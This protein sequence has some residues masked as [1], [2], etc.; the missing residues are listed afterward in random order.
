MILASLVLL[1]VATAMVAIRIALS[2]HG[3]VQHDMRASLPQV[4]QLATSALLR[5]DLSA[6]W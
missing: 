6:L 5:A 1:G 4:C 3:Q 2:L